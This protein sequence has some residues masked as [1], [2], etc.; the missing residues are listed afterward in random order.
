MARQYAWDD[1]F[2]PGTEVLAKKLGV[3]DPNKLH[4][5]E[6][7]VG[8]TPGRDHPWRRPDPAHV[9]RRAQGCPWRDVPD[10]FGPWQTVWKR[11][12]RF[13]RDGTWDQI[14]T[15]LLADADAAGDLD[16][17]V[18]VD[19]TVCRV[20]QHGAGLTMSNCFLT[21]NNGAPWA[22]N[23]DGFDTDT[24][25]TQGLSSRQTRRTRGGD[26][27][28]PYVGTFRGHQRGLSHGHG[29]GCP[30]CQAASGDGSGRDCGQRDVVLVG[31]EGQGDEHDLQS[32]EDHTF[33]REGD[34]VPVADQGALVS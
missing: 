9:R 29:Q 1:Y 7:I 21:D 19:S 18:S 8:R 5:V 2:W 30:Y 28:R 27:H 32:F 13:S 12:A 33:E 23:G 15:E 31:P 10:R 25:T 11:H 34:G 24:V 6:Y 20:H 17:R 4:R 16:W 26:F 3:Q 22:V 14:L